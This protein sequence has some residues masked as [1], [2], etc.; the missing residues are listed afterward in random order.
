[1]IIEVY[2]ILYPKP[3]RAIRRS[4]AGWVTRPAAGAPSHAWRLLGDDIPSLMGNR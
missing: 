4:K 2:H 3:V 1:M